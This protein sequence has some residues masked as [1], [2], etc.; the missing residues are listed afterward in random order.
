MPPTRMCFSL[1]AHT[2]NTPAT[3]NIS[4]EGINMNAIGT[5]RTSYKTKQDCPIQPL[6]TSGGLGRV[7][8]LGTVRRGIDG[9]RN[10]F[11]HLSTLSV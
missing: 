8:A 1:T 11:S 10:L 5:I 3:E 9:H 6:Y 7:E 2:A 4:L